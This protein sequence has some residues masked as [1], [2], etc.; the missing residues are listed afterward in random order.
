MSCE[1]CC[2]K[3]NKSL[4]AKVTC[5][6]GFDACKTCV[7]T[8][9]LSTAKD[10][11]CM[12]CKNRWSSK[13]VVDNLN[14]SYV[15]GDYKKHRKIL[16]VDREIS[17]TPEL[18][19]LVERKR[20]IE[21]KNKE[22]KK[23]NE[24][25]KAAKK[26][27]Y[28][29]L[30]KRKQIDQEI[31]AIE[32]GDTKTE[33]KKFIMPCPADNCKGYLSTQYKCEV[34]KLYTCP[35][36]Y[37]I[38]G[39]TKEDE[40]TCI[41]SNLQSA[42]LIKKETKGCPQ[43][44]VRIY[45]ISGCNQ[46][47][48]TECKVAFNWNT[49]SIEHGG[50]IHNP[51][52][53]QYLREQNNGETPPRNPG[54]ILCGGIIRYEHL[55]GL[56]GYLKNFNKPEWFDTLKTDEVIAEFIDKFQINEVRH[57]TVMMMHLHLLI[58]HITTMNL[59]LSREKVRSLNNNDH[60]TV[61]Y[62]MGGKTKEELSSDIM[63]HDTARKKETEMLNV[64]EL[65]SVVGIEKYNHLSEI[66]KTHS[67]QEDFVINGLIT[68]IHAIISLITEYNTLIEYCNRQAVDISKTYNKSVTVIKYLPHK[69][70]Y[71]LRHGRFREE[72]LKGLFI[73]PKGNNAE[74]SSSSDNK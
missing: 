27:Y 64:Y 46:M 7:R 44:G 17:K 33:R 54:D 49:G 56:N 5:I 70:D 45:K 3:F 15:N 55:R 24:E 28:A 58:N 37:E 22:L 41:E 60:L 1:I 69:F 8:Y 2:E 29:I 38:V 12:K 39:Y 57:F 18:M 42:A 9:L 23:V 66:Y 61:L 48:C 35:D 74:A 43:C 10:P 59:R 26:V 14:R 19:H 71:G 62:I 34:C 65:L 63:K 40:H 30:T 67:Q 53:Y 36:C 11:H 21:D 68:V 31:L 13:F 32:K 25:E 20:L 50:Q 73:N 4:N 6:C 51:H 47:W 72:D 16:L 52:Y